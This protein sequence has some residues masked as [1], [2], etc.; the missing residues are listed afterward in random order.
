MKADNS[1]D[2]LIA[3]VENSHHLLDPIH[4]D[5][6]ISTIM[7]LSTRD[8]NFVNVRR[9]CLLHTLINTSDCFE[10][11][12]ELMLLSNMRANNQGKAFV[13]PNVCD[14][15]PFIISFLCE[16]DSVFQNQFEAYRDFLLCAIFL[17]DFLSVVF[18]KIFPTMTYVKIIN[19]F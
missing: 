4:R 11:D 13:T 9:S 5:E 12:L 18:S 17:V 1:F 19:Q 15:V 2:D 3:Y 6:V 16:H 14:V 10:A 7:Q 8:V